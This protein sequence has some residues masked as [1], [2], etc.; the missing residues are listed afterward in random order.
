MIQHTGTLTNNEFEKLRKEID[1]LNQRADR[2][3]M[4][5]ITVRIAS[6]DKVTRTNEFGFDYVIEKINVEV[7]GS[8]PVIDGWTPVARIEPTEAGNLVHA[9]PGAATNPKWRTTNMNCDHCHTNRNRK[10]VVILRHIDG[11]EIQVGRNCLADFLRDADAAGLIELATQICEL[12]IGGEEDDCYAYYNGEPV[13]ELDTFIRA[14]I[15]VIRTC[16][17]LGRTKANDQGRMATCDIVRVFLHP[18]NE[19]DRKFLRELGITISDL[20]KEQAEKVIEW[21]K[22]AE[23]SD[24]LDNLRIIANLGVVSSS[25]AGYAASMVIAYLNAMDKLAKAAERKAEVRTQIGEVGQRLRDLN[26]TVKR[27]RSTESQWGVTTIITFDLPGNVELTWFAS[28]DKTQDWIVG[29][30]YK[31]DCTVKGHKDDEKWG[32]STIVN[33]VK[34]VV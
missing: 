32:V 27:I 30:S 21:A 13:D 6:V 14:T 16:G 22:T 7:T 11:R 26:V 10:D 34:D 4:P 2:L 24:Y 3:G 19:A 5:R 29:E 17:F 28:G 23:G 20:D 1:Q 9:A 25:H 8:I 18:Q 31:I 12:K 15:A 33:R